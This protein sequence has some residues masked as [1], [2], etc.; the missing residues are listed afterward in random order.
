MRQMLGWKR[1][2]YRIRWTYA[3]KSL[4]TLTTYNWYHHNCWIEVYRCQSPYDRD[5][6]MIS[7]DSTKYEKTSF[8]TLIF[9]F[10]VF[11]RN[12]HQLDHRLSRVTL[13]SSTYKLQGA[14][15]T[16]IRVWND[17]DIDHMRHFSFL[18]PHLKI[19]QNLCPDLAFQLI[20]ANHNNLWPL[21]CCTHDNII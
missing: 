16:I 1:I 11:C 7:V 13:W 21:H 8:R 18:E 4:K 14:A 3:R 17:F 2:T 6:G 10:L 15:L 5:N 20:I 19:N 9:V 12:E